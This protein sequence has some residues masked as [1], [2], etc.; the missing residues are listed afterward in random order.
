MTKISAK[1]RKELTSGID[2]EIKSDKTDHIEAYKVAA[3]KG[4]LLS[5]IEKK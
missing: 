1:R 3:H 2:Y 4:H 5:R